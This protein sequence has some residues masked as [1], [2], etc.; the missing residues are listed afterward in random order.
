MGRLSSPRARRTVRLVAVLVF[1]VFLGLAVA[2]QWD[3]I[4]DAAH[5]LSPWTVVLSLLPALLAIFCSMLSWR[6]VLADLGSPLPVRVALRIFFLGQ[7]GK[8]VPGTVW[9]LVVQMELGRDHKVPRSRT[10]A[11][12]VVAVALGLTAALVVVAVTLPF[13]GDGGRYVGAL[14]VLPFAVVGLHPRIL[15][16]VMNFGLRLIRRQP[17]DRPLTVLG[18]LRGVG[19]A[20]CCW[21]LIGVQVWVIARDLGADESGFRLYAICLGSYALGWAAGF[22]VFIAPAG[23]GAREAALVVLLGSI[24]PTGAATLLALMCRLVLTLTDVV[25]AAVAAVGS[26]G[27]MAALKAERLHA[28]SAAAEE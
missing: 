6:A 21:M 26:R 23:A 12:G 7:L 20:G 18:V 15:T 2:N 24:L 17:L 16:P 3:D 10:A 1:L 8:Y 11:T 9:P 27:T 5:A 22:L 28:A 19:W 14:A 13:I 25:W 4:T